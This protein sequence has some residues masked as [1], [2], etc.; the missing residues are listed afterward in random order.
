MSSAFV[1]RRARR[2]LPARSAWPRRSGT[3][4]R[5][6]LR[7]VGDGVE[8]RGPSARRRASRRR[9]RRSRSRRR[10]RSGGRS[11]VAL[12]ASSRRAP[13]SATRAASTRAG[14]IDRGERDRGERGL[15]R[16]ILVAGDERDA[17][18]PRRH[19]RRVGDARGPSGATACASSVCRCSG[20]RGGA[21]GMGHGLRAAIG[22]TSAFSMTSF[23]SAGGSRARDRAPTRGRRAPRP[24]CDRGYL[25]R[26]SFA[27][28]AGALRV[29]VDRHRA[30]EEDLRDEEV[31][32]RA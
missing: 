6:L 29:A 16:E 4:E 3:D 26:N 12:S 2:G 1:A 22:S 7:L 32:R 27:S 9:R 13:R 18:E 31:R 24:R 19:A 20:S 11:S 5:E 17:A 30:R 21:R 10:A 25:S 15:A 8:A 14:R 23:T 28:S